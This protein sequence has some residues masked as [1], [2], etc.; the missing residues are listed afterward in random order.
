MQ[1]ESIH[2]RAQDVRP[3]GIFV[4]VKGFVSDG[5]AYIDQAIAQG[6]A[7]VVVQHPLDCDAVVIQVADTRRALALLAD[8]FYGHPSRKL[9][10]VGITGTNGKTTTAFLVEQILARQGLKVGVI[11]TINYRYAGR[12]FRQSRDDA[13]VS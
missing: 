6:A 12:G 5:H 4:A 10:I 7:A 3:G 11:G 8:R 9:F 1:I 13:G 2:C